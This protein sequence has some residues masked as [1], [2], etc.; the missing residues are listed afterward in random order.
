ME[1]GDGADLFPL[2]APAKKRCRGRPSNARDK[3][4]Y[5]H[6]SKRTQFC[7]KCNSP[8]H[9][10]QHGPHEDPALRKPRAPPR[11]S[12][13]KLTRH[14]VNNYRGKKQPAAVAEVF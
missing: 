13:C 1:G 10:R 6:L 5:E 7:K 4:S 14:N 3:P 9:T 8:R 12:G 11:C 2:R